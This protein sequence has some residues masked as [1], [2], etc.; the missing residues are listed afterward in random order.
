MKKE[1]IEILMKEASKA[2]KKNE[3][4]VGAI[5]EYNNRV[6]SKAHNVREKNNNVLGHAEILAIQKAVKKIKSWKLNGCN[7]YVTLKPCSMCLE[8]IKNARIDNVYYLIDKKE[9]KKEYNKTNLVQTNVRVEYL[10]E[11]E[12][13]LKSFF[14]KMRR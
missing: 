14:G 5:I 4:P 11:Y 2:Y 1:Y 7:L 8:I 13:M 12:K 6:I 10:E 3:V 9:E